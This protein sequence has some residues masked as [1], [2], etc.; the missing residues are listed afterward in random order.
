[1]GLIIQ[2][3]EHYRFLHYH[4]NQLWET[5]KHLEMLCSF[6]TIQSTMSMK[7]ERNYSDHL[8]QQLKLDEY[9]SNLVRF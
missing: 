4:S 8:L 1:M 9:Y 5:L 3:Q 7:T 2:S 6:Y